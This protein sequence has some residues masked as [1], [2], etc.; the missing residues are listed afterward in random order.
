MITFVVVVFT[1]VVAI[2]IA[3]TIPIKEHYTIPFYY[4]SM[5]YGHPE[6]QYIYN[7][8][9]GKPLYYQLQLY[10]PVRT[11]IPSFT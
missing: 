2:A 6:K 1:I 7:G 10:S 9:Y 4:D 3:T 5:Y 8:F 11:I